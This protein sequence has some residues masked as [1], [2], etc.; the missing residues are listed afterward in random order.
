VADERAQR[1]LAAILAAD[2]V[3]YSR[4]IEQDEAGTLEALK[5]HRAE[6]IDP[7]I[8]EHNGRIVKLTG[9][10]LLVEFPSVVNAVACAV[11]IQQAMQGRNVGL[12]DDQAIW[13]R[14]GVNVGDIIVEAEDIFGD[15]VNVAARLEGIA[16]PGGIAVSAMAHDHIGNRLDLH[17]EDTGQ[18]TLK[19]IDRPVRV[20]RAILDH[21][22]ASPRPA[23]SLPDKPSIA[24]LP[25]DNMSS[26]PEQS[27]F[28]DGIVEEITAALARIRGFFVIARNSAFAYRGK[29]FNVQQVGRELGVRYVLEGSVRR[30]GNHLRIAAQLIETE[31]ARHIWAESFK[32]NIAEVFDLQ[33]NITARVVGAIQPSIQMAEIERA[34][35][36]RPS[37]L[38]T[39]DLVMQALPHVWALAREGNAS[40]TE[41]LEKALELDPEYPQALSLLAWCHAQRAVYNWSSTPE[42]DKREALRLAERAAELSGEDP[43]VLAVLAAAHTVVRNIATAGMLLKRAL[44]IDPNSAFAWNRSGWL[45]LYSS[46]AEAAVAQFEQA[47]R[48]SPFDPMV[49]TCYFGIGCAH[50]IAGA[51]ALAVEWFLRGLAER[52]HA[53]W[54]HRTLIPA[55]VE[56]GRMDEALERTRELLCAYPNLTIRAVREAMVFKSDVMDRHAAGLRLVGVPE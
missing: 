31:N 37:D 18:H 9:D 20:Y 2:V 46:K 48:L 23:L 47:L 32:G 24:I 13:L 43:F 14:I 3:G 8:A 29:S 44:V 42:A 54:L 12:P 41:L 51:S 15:G 28:A 36:K 5:A 17:F 11:D 6:L 27:Y 53:V 34:R 4:L 38:K 22:P 16:P 56:A 55:L 21:P 40:A 35:R 10:G 1:R 25:F 26:D 19:N 52:P 7:K 50:F 39:Y 45:S 33:D 49:F 30:A